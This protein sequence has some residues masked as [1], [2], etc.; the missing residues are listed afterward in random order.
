MLTHTI[1]PRPPQLLLNGR[2]AI[3]NHGLPRGRILRRN[4]ISDPRQGY[5]LYLPRGVASEAARVLVTVHGIS[6]NAEEQARAFMADAEQ[7]DTLLVAPIFDSARFRDYQRLGRA[8]RGPRSDLALQ[9][10]L[11]EVALLTGADCRRP[12]LFGYSGGGQFVHRYAFAHPLQ[13]GKVVLG[14]PGWYSL[15]DPKRRF[16]YGTARCKGLPG[17]AFEA[18]DYLRVP[19]Y[20]LVGELDHQRDDELNKSRRL[21]RRQGEQRI[22]RGRNWIEAMRRA[23]LRHGLATEYRLDLLPDADHSFSACIDGGLS[24]RVFGFL[25][26]TSHGESQTFD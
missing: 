22:A 21:D 9:R 16:P 15:P 2:Q 6:R 23:A 1:E 7:N 13:V 26:A 20:T 10:I 11:R 19:F 25:S 5:L 17:I 8:G 12:D 14:A 4:L 18:A 3:R 24:G